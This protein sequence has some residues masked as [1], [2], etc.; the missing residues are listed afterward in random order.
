MACRDKSR[1]LTFDERLQLMYDKGERY[2]ED[3]TAYDATLDDIDMD[4]VKAYMKRIGYGKSAMEYLQ[5]NKGFVTYKGDIP[6]VSAA[7]ILLFGKH[8]QTFFPRARVRFIKYFGTEEKVGREMNVIKM[9]LSM[10]VFLNRYRKP[11]N[12]LKRR[13][14]SIPISERTVSSG[15]TVN[16]PSL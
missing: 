9:L 16:I 12:I 3:S 11:L 4:A 2:Y 14:R 1:K 15:P 6:Q 13:S 5:E 10:V 8:P 7:C